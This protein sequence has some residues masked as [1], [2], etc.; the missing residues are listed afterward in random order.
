[1]GYIQSHQALSRHR[2][3][4][5]MVGMLK[6]DRHKVLGHLHEL[7]WWGL[8][9]ADAE[10]N[11][12]AIAEELI[13]E[14]AGWPLKGAKLFVKALLE[15][16]GS[17]RPGFLERTDEGFRLHDWAAYYGDFLEERTHRQIQNREAQR[18]HRAKVRGLEAVPNGSADT[19]DT[20]P[21]SHHVITASGTTENHF[22]ITGTAP[23][24]TDKADETAK[25]ALTSAMTGQQPR[26]AGHTPNRAE[27]N[28]ALRRR[29]PDDEK[30]GIKSVRAPQSNTRI[31]DPAGRPNAAQAPP[32]SHPAEILIDDE[33]ASIVE[34][35]AHDFYDNDV[36]QTKRTLH[37]LWVNSGAGRGQFFDVLTQA[38]AEVK[39][40]RSRSAVTT[41]DTE[42]GRQK[43]WPLC[44]AL[45]QERL[46]TKRKARSA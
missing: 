40:A 10:G 24:N 46:P 37:H 26:D 1:M 13:A 15:C 18:R 19:A 39:D 25:S 12:G 30:K 2:K 27:L 16:G 32:E 23:V 45:L 21:S 7:W 11:L 4:L 43:G 28:R 38:I 22:V 9:N 31:R 33:L 36:A 20:T 35:R 29:L 5:A 6:T 3:V 34:A 42:T 14:G 8:D 17:S 41:R 44:L